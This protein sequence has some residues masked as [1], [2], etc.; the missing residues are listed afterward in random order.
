MHRVEVTCPKSRCSVAPDSWVEVS[1]C[2]KDGPFSVITSHGSHFY[3]PIYWT[4]HRSTEKCETF[5]EGTHMRSR[6]STETNP[7][8]SA[9]LLGFVMSFGQEDANKCDLS[10]AWSVLVLRAC[11]CL[12]VIFH[13]RERS[14]GQ[15]ACQLFKSRRCRKKPRPKP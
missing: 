1:L 12:S 2:V 14:A 3:Y 13:H 8:P 4:G 11:L 5:A 7:K 15:V 6:G 10:K 9:T